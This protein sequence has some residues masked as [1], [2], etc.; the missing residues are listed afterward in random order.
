[1]EILV[2]IP[3]VVT[4]SGYFAVKMVLTGDE[5]QQCDVT[6]QIKATEQFFAVGIF[7]MMFKIILTSESVSQ[8]LKSD[9]SN[10]VSEHYFPVVLFIM[11]Y[12]SI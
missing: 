8:I 3:R 6:M 9:H 7:I 10:E 11:L 2:R 12:R 4:L 1:M 5:I